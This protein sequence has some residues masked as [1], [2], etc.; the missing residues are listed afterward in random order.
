VIAVKGGFSSDVTPAIGYP[1]ISRNSMGNSWI[2][3]EFPR[4]LSGGG[5]SKTLVYMY[6]CAVMINK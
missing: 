2:F 4:Q 3:Q 1:G 6:R 5:K